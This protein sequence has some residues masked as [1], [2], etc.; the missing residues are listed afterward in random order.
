MLRFAPQHWWKTNF[1]RKERI[2]DDIFYYKNIRSFFN[3]ESYVEY[4]KDLPLDNKRIS[5]AYA[6]QVYSLA[7][8]VIP[9][10]FKLLKISGWI[11]TLSII[12]S[13]G[14]FFLS[15]NA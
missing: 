12:S 10:K 15:I 6:N 14:L 2:Q 9:Y 8:Y 4:L 7:T 3:R 13:L 5:K 1:S 11:L